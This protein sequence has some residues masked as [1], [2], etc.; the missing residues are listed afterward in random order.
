MF[1]TFDKIKILN[2][3][4]AYIADETAPAKSSAKKP[5]AKTAPT[6]KKEVYKTFYANGDTVKVKIDDPEWTDEVYFENPKGD[7]ALRCDISGVT[8]GPDG[9]TMNLNFFGQFN[10]YSTV[11]TIMDADDSIEDVAFHDE[12]S[13]AFKICEHE[14]M[15]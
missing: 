3:K 15:Y 6:S 7:G 8:S 11:V 12:L 14:T 10:D 9:I 5:V 1:D 4:P 13:R 2:K